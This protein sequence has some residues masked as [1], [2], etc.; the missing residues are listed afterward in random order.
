MSPSARRMGIECPFA[1]HPSEVPTSF[2]NVLLSPT[3]NHFCPHHRLLLAVV[4]RKTKTFLKNVAPRAANNRAKN[5][6]DKLYFSAFAGST[7]SGAFLFPIEVDENRHARADLAP[8]R[9]APRSPAKSL[10]LTS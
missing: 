6:H 10:F 5:R 8:G 9:R 1:P 4:K 7:D 3:C 2:Y